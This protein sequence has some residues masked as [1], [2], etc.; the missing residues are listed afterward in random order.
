[1]TKFLN[2]KKSLVALACLSAVTLVGCGGSSSSNSDDGSTSVPDVVVQPDTS[3]SSYEY[4]VTLTNV[5]N[6]QPLSPI[7]LVTHAEDVSLF[8]VGVEASDALE[9]LAE[10]GDN[11]D[12]LALATNVDTLSDSAP[13][14]PGDTYTGTL[15]TEDTSLNLTIL[16][17]LVNTNDAITGLNNTDLA[18]YTVGEKKSFSLSVYDSGT[19]ANTETKETIP[20]PVGSG[21]DGGFSS[22][23]DDI[24]NVVTMHAGVISNQ[25]GLADSVLDGSY[26]FDNVVAK[27]TITRVK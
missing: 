8:E 19:E 12:I 25:D 10:A 23:R 15:V 9:L 17:M 21:A 11:T 4:E 3:E 5:T 16:S 13:L 26:R 24:I 1:M 22:D 18:E 7:T 6:N 2:A 27:V 14:A 20:G